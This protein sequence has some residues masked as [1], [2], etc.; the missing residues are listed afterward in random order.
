MLKR[1]S[2]LNL[3]VRLILF[4]HQYFKKNYTYQLLNNCQ[5]KIS[6][7]ALRTYRVPSEQGRL[8][9]EGGRCVGVCHGDKGDEG[10]LTEHTAQA[11]TVRPCLPGVQCPRWLLLCKRKSPCFP[12]GEGVEFAFKRVHSG[13]TA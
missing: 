9:A 6:L 1:K 10:I 11:Q 2:A 5:T 7:C 4:K 3:F 8:E 13:Q 12:A